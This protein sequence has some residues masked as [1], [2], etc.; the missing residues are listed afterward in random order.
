MDCYWCL[1]D[2]YI[3]GASLYKQRSWQK[4]QVPGDILKKSEYPYSL[5]IWGY[6]ATKAGYNLPYSA[7]LSIQYFGSK[8]DL[9]I[10]NL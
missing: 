1:L 8:S 4:N 6:K 5:P 2:E 10:N 3:V 9:V 7:G